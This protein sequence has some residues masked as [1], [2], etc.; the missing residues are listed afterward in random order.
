ML[1]MQHVEAT[2]GASRAARESTGTVAGTM[3]Y[4]VLQILFIL[5]LI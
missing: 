2:S 5:T 4:D 3:P 1:R